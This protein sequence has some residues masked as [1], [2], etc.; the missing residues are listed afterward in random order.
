LMITKLLMSGVFILLIYD[1][2]Q[3]SSI[4]NKT[5]MTLIVN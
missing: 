4:S 5:A 3:N 1:P 2:L